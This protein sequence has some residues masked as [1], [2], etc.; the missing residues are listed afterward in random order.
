MILKDAALRHLKAMREI[1][2]ENLNCFIGFL[3][4]D[5][6]RRLPPA[7]LWEYCTRGNLAQVLDNPLINLDWDFQASFIADLARVSLVLLRFFTPHI[8][9]G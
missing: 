2:H 6:T 4:G 1:R 7:L 3:M 9:V 5:P 8:I